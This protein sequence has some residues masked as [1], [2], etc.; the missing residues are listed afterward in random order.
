[1][2]RTHTEHG[3]VRGTPVESVVKFD[4]SGKFAGSHI[5]LGNTWWSLPD[6]LELLKLGRAAYVAASLDPVLAEA[7]LAPPAEVKP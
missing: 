5:V 3:V 1:V 2:K 4:A 6:F 7:Q